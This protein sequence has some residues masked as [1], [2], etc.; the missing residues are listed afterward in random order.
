MKKETKR[1]VMSKAMVDKI[2]KIVCDTFVELEPKN[3]DSFNNGISVAIAA[4]L[5][6]RQHRGLF[7]LWG[8]GPDSLEKQI[9]E[10]PA[11]KAFKKLY[12]NIMDEHK[13]E[14]DNLKL[15]ITMLESKLNDK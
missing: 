9:E 12:D 10:N 14:A 7:F 2:K 6:E 11:A 3:K 8:F 13:R 5:G 15:R 4:V 1:P